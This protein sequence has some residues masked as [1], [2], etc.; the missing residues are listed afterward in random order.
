M[1]HRD[2]FNGYLLPALTL[3]LAL[4]CGCRTEEGK[5]E[6]ALSTFH[7]FVEVNQDAAQR[8]RPVP[9]YRNAPSTVNIE[10]EPF[11]TEAN[12]S[13]ARV[14][15]AVGG[16]AIRIRLD[17]RGTWLLEQYTVANKGKHLAIQT[18]FARP[19]T[20]ELH[21]SR[22]LAAPIISA[23]I[24]DG[25]LLFTPDATRE[26]AYQIVLGLNNVA[27]KDNNT[28]DKQTMK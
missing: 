2:R 24:S 27:K 21:Q 18:Q 17:R 5:R 28:P 15:E 11:L 14:V 12:V 1:N 16:F 7:V 8:S 6:K 13:E 9:I 10:A 3:A 19:E 4:V 20:P 23:R 26:E 22:W 25:I